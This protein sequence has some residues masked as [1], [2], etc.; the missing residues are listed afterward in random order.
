MQDRFKAIVGVF[1]LFFENQNILLLRRCNTN[2][3]NGSYSVPAGHLESGESLAQAMIRELQ[4]EVGVTIEPDQL[5]LAH[6][7]SYNAEDGHRIHF[8]FRIMPPYE[9]PRNAESDK[10]DD[11]SWFA[12]D[13]LPENTIPYVREVLAQIQQGEM[14]SE[15][16]WD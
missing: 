12:F 5:T 10:C 8:Y 16:A 6:V 1:G 2:F 11:L 7:Q 13:A 9:S 15:T 14:Y 4:E 3:A